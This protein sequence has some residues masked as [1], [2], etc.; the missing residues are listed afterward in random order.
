MAESI[1]NDP[2]DDPMPMPPMGKINQL[3]YSMLKSVTPTV[4]DKNLIRAKAIDLVLAGD[5]DEYTWTI[6]GKRFTEEKYIEIKENEVITFRFI[7]KTMMHHPMHLHGH[8]FR[9]LNGQG[10]FAPLFHTIDVPPMMMGMPTP[11][12]VIEFHANEPGIW[13]L[14]C[15]NLYH[16]KMGMARLVKYK[17]FKPSP[18]DQAALI[19]D[20]K[21]W[22][23]LM[24]HDDD[25][26]MNTKTTFS[27]NKTDLK[28]TM[29]KG[30]YELEAELELDENQIKNLDGEIILKK[31]IDNWTRVGTGIMI[32]DQKVYAALMTSYRAKNDIMVSGYLRHDGK[33]IIRLNKSFQISDRVSLNLTPEINYKNKVGAEVE[34]LLNYQVTKRFSIN[35]NATAS[36][37]DKN[38]VGVGF[39]LSF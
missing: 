15:H 38:T 19:K 9:F 26:F 30:N 6:N 24:T 8:F 10:D 5:M 20:Q 32:E 27:T 4:L 21:K 23:P 12:V 1:N 34:A 7:N 33:A 39:S 36:K 13:F 17:D 18:E 31:V 14:H 2:G 37:D 29:K 35:A 22:G 11:P 16:M 28:L 25:L 3:K